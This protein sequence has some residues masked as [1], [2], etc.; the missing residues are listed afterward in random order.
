MAL[1]FALFVS[2]SFGFAVVGYLPE[3]RFGSY[4]FET[5]SNTI[6]HLIFFSLE[7]GPN[8][9]ILH[10]DRFPSNLVLLDAKAARAKNSQMKLMICFGGNGRSTHFAKMSGNEKSRAVFV[11]NVADLGKETR[12]RSRFVCFGINSFSD[13][14]LI[15]IL[16][17]LYLIVLIHVKCSVLVNLS[18]SLFE[19]HSFFD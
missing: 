7:P 6:T 8:G 18:L 19:F 9:E 15:Q 5:A 1:L 14:M 12:K 11:K 3:W 13:L 16:L 4:N 10:M 17:P 2:L